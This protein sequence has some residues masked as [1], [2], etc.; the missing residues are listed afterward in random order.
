MPSTELDGDCG[1]WCPS[2]ICFGKELASFNIISFNSIQILVNSMISS[3][4]A[5]LHIPCVHISTH[6]LLDI[7]PEDA[8]LSE[9]NQKNWSQKDSTVGGAYVFHIADL[10]SIPATPY[11]PTS[12]T[13]IPEYH[14]VWPQNAKEQKSEKQGQIPNVLTNL[15]NAEKQN[16]EMEGINNGQTLGPGL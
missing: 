15:W 13:R 3:C 6:L 11:S 16:K 8:M 4:L 7:C 12:I 5:A 1:T 14:Q 9:S 2:K 10:D